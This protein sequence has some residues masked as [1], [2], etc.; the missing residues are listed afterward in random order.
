MRAIPVQGS[1]SDGTPLGLVQL[2]APMC[3]HIW[4]GTHVIAHNYHILAL[5]GFPLMP[6]AAVI[7]NISMQSGP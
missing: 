2:K 1:N 3:R 5:G 6:V 7:A 4:K